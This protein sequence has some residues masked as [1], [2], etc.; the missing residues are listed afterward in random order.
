[1]LF[2]QLPSYVPT[3]GLVGWWPFN[4]NA[5]DISGNGNNGTFNGT[6]GLWYDRFGSANSAIATDGGFVNVPNSATLQFNGGITISAWI[7]PNVFNNPSIAWFSKGTNVGAPYS[8]TSSILPTNHKASVSM[9]NNVSVANEIS[10]NSTVPYGWVNVISTFNGSVAKLL[11][12][13][14]KSPNLLLLDFWNVLTYE[15][16]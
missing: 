3:N 16:Q 2:S 6:A 15:I 14:L 5:N 12:H 4:G 10:S 13:P 11:F 1:M 8:W 7:S 9:F